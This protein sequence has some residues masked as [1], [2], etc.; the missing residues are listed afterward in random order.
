MAKHIIVGVASHERN[1][2]N[3]IT[4]LKALCDQDHASAS[5]AYMKFFPHR[6]CTVCEISQSWTPSDSRNEKETIAFRPDAL[7]RPWGNENKQTHGS[8]PTMKVPGWQGAL[9]PTLCVGM[10]SWTLCIRVIERDFQING[11]EGA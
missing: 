11:H 7:A 8:S 9:V 2:K 3:T 6:P 4:H 5:M 10:H 1:L